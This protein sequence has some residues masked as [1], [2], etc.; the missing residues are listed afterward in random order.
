[1][2]QLRAPMEK[3]TQLCQP[4]TEKKKKRLEADATLYISQLSL[5]GYAVVARYLLLVLYWASDLN[6]LRVLSK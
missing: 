4:F 5:Q 6:N 1:M 2:G 3:G